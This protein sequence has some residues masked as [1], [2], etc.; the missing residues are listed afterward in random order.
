MFIVDCKQKNIYKGRKKTTLSSKEVQTNLV[1][2]KNKFKLINSI[3]RIG[4]SYG[5]VY[6]RK[7]RGRTSG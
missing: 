6:V 3:K 1:W 5:R 2:E 4:D 7:Q